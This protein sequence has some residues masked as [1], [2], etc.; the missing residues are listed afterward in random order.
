MLIHQ[1]HK[2]RAIAIAMPLAVA[3]V[4]SFAP[5]IA[6]ADGVR[7]TTAQPFTYVDSGLS[8]NNPAPATIAPNARSA[9][10]TTSNQTAAASTRPGGARAASS[11]GTSIVTCIGRINTPQRFSATIDA[12]GSAQC[13]GLEAAIWLSVQLYRNGQPW[14]YKYDYETTPTFSAAADASTSCT[15]GNY[16]ATADIWIQGFPWYTPQAVVMHVWSPT[17]KVTC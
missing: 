9:Q 3:V 16:Y 5:G 15:S 14:A 17:V 4:L 2:P 6:H 13:D 8:V 1:S 7:G 10:T 11:T 12:L